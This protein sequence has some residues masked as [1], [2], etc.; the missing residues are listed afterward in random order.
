M[1]DNIL[2]NQWQESIPLWF[3]IRVDTLSLITTLIIGNFCIITRLNND[4]VILSM[5]LSYILSLQTMVIGTI[6]AYIQIEKNMVSI[7]RCT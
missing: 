4:P 1:N 7:E 2:A 5:L 3:N 6:Q